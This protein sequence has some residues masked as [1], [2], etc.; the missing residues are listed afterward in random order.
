M[1]LSAPILTKEFRARISNESHPITG[2]YKLGAK[3]AFEKGFNLIYSFPVPAWLP[4]IKLMFPKIGIDMKKVVT[5]QIECSALS[6]KA[7]SDEK[8]KYSVSISSSFNDDYNALWQ[9]AVEN[10]PLNNAIVRNS[11]WLNWK[12]GGHIVLEVRQENKLL[13]YAAVKKENGLVEDALA[14]TPDDLETVI[15]EAI[16]ALSVL[17]ITLPNNEIKMM[18]THA[19]APIIE[20]LGFQE[21]D[22]KF[23]FWCYSP[24]NSISVEKLQL[25]R[26]FMMPND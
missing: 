13:G 5:A 21:I 24:D 26:W 16:I 4:V 2:M 3:T 7:F 11:N 9:S 15:K 17:K 20:K 14:H 10:F 12:L 25:A 18:Q 22:Y 23:G 1:R 19:T 6:A 8:N